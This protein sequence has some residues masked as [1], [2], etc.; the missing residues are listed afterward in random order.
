MPGTWLGV[1]VKARI[2]FSEQS[3]AIRINVSISKMRKLRV[4][5]VEQGNQLLHLVSGRPWLQTKYVPH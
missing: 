2:D 5:E 4:K 1:Y 3:R